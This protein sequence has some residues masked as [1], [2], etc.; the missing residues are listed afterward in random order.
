M[1]EQEQSPEQPVKQ[2]EKKNIYK[3]E[4]F[5]KDDKEATKDYSSIYH[6]QFINTG[7]L[8]DI[9]ADTLVDKSSS[10]WQFY[11]TFVDTMNNRMPKEA[12]FP[13]GELLST[14]WAPEVR[15]VMWYKRD[16]IKVAIYIGLYGKDL[17]ISWRAFYW[18]ISYGKVILIALLTIV[19]FV[20]SRPSSNPYF[21]P[22][23]FTSNLYTALGLSPLWLSLL[24][25]FL[26]RKG[27]YLAFFRKNPS[28]FVY[29]DL[30]AATSLV[31]KSVI[32]AAD[33]IGVAEAKL[34]AVEPIIKQRKPRI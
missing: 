3:I 4:P 21:Y 8:L 32:Q 29:D 22:D 10:K 19:G 7:M 16:R 5:P 30:M 28:E 1:S 13:L 14:G 6:N 12:G 15:D 2:D 23:G 31:H 26:F 33:S 20:I 17:Y 24:W 11:N 25:G 34:A 18:A 27:D 9:W